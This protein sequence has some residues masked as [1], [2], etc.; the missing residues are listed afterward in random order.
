MPMALNL[1]QQLFTLANFGD[2]KGLVHYMVTNDWTKDTSKLLHRNFKNQSILS[3]MCRFDCVKAFTTMQKLCDAKLFE[4]GLHTYDDTGHS[5]IGYALASNSVQI[6]ELLMEAYPKSVLNYFKEERYRD[7]HDD[8]DDQGILYYSYQN[9]N[10]KLTKW[11]VKNRVYKDDK[12][13][14]LMEYCNYGADHLHVIK[15]LLSK[16]ILGGDEDGVCQEVDKK[17]S[18]GWTALH[19][20][21]KCKGYKIVE[22]ILD[23]MPNEHAFKSL[24]ETNVDGDTP[25]QMMARF[26]AFKFEFF[27]QSVANGLSAS[28][29]HDLAMNENEKGELCIQTTA[30]AQIFEHL[31]DSIANTMKDKHAW[32]QL[33]NKCFMIA[34]NTTAISHKKAQGII[35]MDHIQTDDAQLLEYLEARDSNGMSALLYA[36]KSGTIEIGKRVFDLMNDLKKDEDLVFTT[37]NDGWNLFHFAC[38]NTLKHM[39]FICEE[40]KMKKEKLQSVIMACNEP[41]NMTPLMVCCQRGKVAN[42][43]YLLAQFGDNHPSKSHY[44]DRTNANGKTAIDIVNE[45]KNKKLLKLLQ[46]S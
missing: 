2:D 18:N 16:A 35:Q 9:K 30:T 21:A 42:A 46:E 14:C 38:W 36:F 25:F 3:S 13:T 45:K 26:S 37:D 27:K 20:A 8:P 44:M 19:Y 11:A 17:D 23:L 4:D 12:R 7:M 22:F 28:Q 41:K 6:L 5:P 43:E 39:K 40:L 10:I 34:C 15:L 32:I 33:L 24:N 1:E 31:F 29:L